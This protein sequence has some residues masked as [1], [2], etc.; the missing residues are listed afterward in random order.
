MCKGREGASERASLHHKSDHSPQDSAC[1]RQYACA[2]ACT[3]AALLGRQHAHLGAAG[4]QVSRAAPWLQG[5]TSLASQ[6]VR[7]APPAG[8]KCTHQ[9]VRAP[10]RAY[11]RPRGRRARAMHSWR[12]PGGTSRCGVGWGIAEGC[13]TAH[14][15]MTASARVDPRKD[16]YRRF[17]SPA[18]AGRDYEI[19]VRHGRFGAA[20][21]PAKKRR[22]AA[23]S[24][25]SRGRGVGRSPW[26]RPS[27][28]ALRRRRSEVCRVFAGQGG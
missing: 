3:Q 14:V 10:V 19:V 25:T 11:L 12:D 8:M 18:I 17:R 16:G 27:D 20:G 15:C 2:R 13:A 4:L 26:W 23:V 9:H 28:W 6:Y 24:R 7:R 21:S 5:P 22:R 1:V